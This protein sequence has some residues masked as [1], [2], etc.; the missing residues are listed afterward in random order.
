[1]YI[2][3]HWPATKE[4]RNNWLKAA[5]SHFTR[6]ALKTERHV[7]VTRNMYDERNIR[8]LD[9]IYIYLT[10]NPTFQLSIRILRIAF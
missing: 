3:I 2:Y 8:I 9:A 6:Y 1:M 7:P 5:I 4:N 10:A